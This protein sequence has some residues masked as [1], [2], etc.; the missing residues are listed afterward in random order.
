MNLVKALLSVAVIK[1]WSM[2][3]IDVKN[4]FLH[5]DLEEEVYM[6][7]L[8]GLPQSCDSQLVCKLHKAICGLKQSPRAWYAKLNSVLI[9]AGFHRSN[10]DSSMFMRSRTA[11]K[12]V[13]LM[14]VDDLIITGDSD[15][16][17]ANL[18][19]ALQQQFDIKDLGLLKYFLGIEMASSHK[20]LFLNQQKYV[21]DL[22]KDAKMSDVKPAKTP[23]D[24]K[25]KFSLEGEPLPNAG[26]YQRLVGKLIY[27]T[28]TWT[29]ISYYMSIVSKFM[30]STTFEH[31]NIVKRILRY[32]NESVGCGIVMKNNRST[33]I[34][35]YCDANWAG[36]SIDR[37]STTGYCIFVGGNLV[38]WKSKKQ[39]VVARSSVEAEY[40]SMTSTTC[41]L[42]WLCKLLCDLGVFNSQSM[43]RYYD[44]QATMHIASNP[45]FHKRTKHIEVDSHYVCEQVQT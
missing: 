2:Y 30:H 17:I 14:Y 22:L 16:E 20:G 5:G 18:K 38:T 43:P 41:E 6:K 31:F 32:L 12:L 40:R 45:L 28:I 19:Q 11:G 24:S 34:M 23:L 9:S 7:L 3:Q 26:Y 1:E 33:Q 10:A 15:E 29:D 42:V 27:L 21:L 8:L 25:L 39:A 44:N 36:N 4:A 37:K 13:V 35:G